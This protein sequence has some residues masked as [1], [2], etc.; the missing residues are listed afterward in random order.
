[1]IMIMMMTVI[2]TKLPMIINTY[3]DNDYDKEYENFRLWY[4][5]FLTEDDNESEDLFIKIMMMTTDDDND[6]EDL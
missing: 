5:S 3:D 6:Y 4:R 1:M 2:I